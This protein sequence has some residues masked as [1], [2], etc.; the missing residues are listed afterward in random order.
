M[1]SLSLLSLL[2][3]ALSLSPCWSEEQTPPIGGAVLHRLVEGEDLEQLAE[4]YDVDSNTILEVNKIKDLQG[5]TV[6]WIPPSPRGWPLHQ[7]RSGET[8][9]RISKKYDIPVTH[10]RQANGQRDNK[11]MP[12]QILI[13]P[14]A[15]KKATV[16]SFGSRSSMTS[17]AG[18]RPRP[19]VTVE[20]WTEVRLPDNR[21]AWVRSESLVMG[22]W[23]PQEPNTLIELARKFETVPY[24]WGG[25][26]P[27][28]FDCSGYVQEVF[29]L[30]GYRIP[31]LADVQYH[32]LVKVKSDELRMGDLVFFNTDGSGVSH[33]GIYVQNGQF[34]HASSSKGVV[35]SGLEETYYR[36][37][38]VGG[39]RIPEWSQ[40]EPQK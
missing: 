10:L 14:R 36:K 1:K 34:L 9:W 35:E 40:S 39:A 31:R 12:G 33:V 5:Q 13:L 3:I 37:R 17:R 23:K 28:G 24:L 26:D 8:F 15:Q 18:Q 20:G 29:R 27:N 30:A 21:H 38:F 7:V 19:V 11:L 22:F 32:S 25:T 2:V 4:L 6:L 16:A